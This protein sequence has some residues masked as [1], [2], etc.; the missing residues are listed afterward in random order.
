M[1][2][3]RRIVERNV[4]VV[5]YEPALEENVFCGAKVICGLEE[6]KSVADVIAANRVTKELYYVRDKVYT[7]DIYARD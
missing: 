1:G 4:E 7:R 6:F 5:I 2:V 3:M